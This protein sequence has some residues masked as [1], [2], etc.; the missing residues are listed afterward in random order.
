MASKPGYDWGKYNGVLA[1][2]ADP[3]VNPKHLSDNNKRKLWQ[4]IK[5]KKPQLADLIV[6]DVNFLALKQVFGAEIV[7]TEKEIHGFIGK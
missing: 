4:A 7:F 6:T 5:T 2:K 3:I 1:S